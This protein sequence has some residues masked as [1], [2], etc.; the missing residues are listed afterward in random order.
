MKKGNLEKIKITRDNK[1][2]KVSFEC[3][4]IYKNFWS[5]S[6]LD[7]L[8]VI[9]QKQD[10]GEILPRLQYTKWP[11]NLILDSAPIILS[12]LSDNEQLISNLKSDLN[13]I[14]D[15]SAVETTRLVPIMQVSLRGAYIPWHQDD[16]FPFVSTTYLNQQTW[17]MNWGGAMLYENKA[18][19]LDQIKNAIYPE[20]N[21]MIVQ[22][23]KY[24]YDNYMRHATSILSPSAPPR[25]SLQM[26]LE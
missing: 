26:W 18:G 3:P 5:S 15:F 21:T 13:T 10:T 4:L 14:W 24:N 7:Q 20:Y 1:T 17:D 23:G 11:Q 12:D 9:L 8:N 6:T 19:G 16:D 2:G 25:I 22:N